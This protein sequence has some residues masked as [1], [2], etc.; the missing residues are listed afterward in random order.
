MQLGCGADATARNRPS[1][2]V[3]SYGSAVPADLARPPGAG[4]QLRGQRRTHTD[5]RRVPRVS[6]REPDP[7]RVSDHRVDGRMGR[8][9]ARTR[10]A[11][12]S[13]GYTA[14]ATRRRL[15]GGGHAPTGRITR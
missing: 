11:S 1:C 10:R 5:F 14:A 8:D 3:S 6:G 12:H 7:P 2:E 13:G 15:H 4:S 9:R